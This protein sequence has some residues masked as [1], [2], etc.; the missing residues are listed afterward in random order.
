[1]HGHTGT[2]D[3]AHLYLIKINMKN[4]AIHYISLGGFY[5]R[6]VLVAF[7]I[8]LDNGTLGNAP[9]PAGQFASVKVNMYRLAPPVYHARNP[10]LFA[11]A[12]RIRGT[13]SRPRFGRKNNVTH[14]WNS[15][16][17]P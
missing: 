4:V 1:M 8:H 3:F 7:D 14:Y 15:Y 11:K 10:P 13:Q 2:K 6:V 16:K 9:Q 12:P 17:K 5:K